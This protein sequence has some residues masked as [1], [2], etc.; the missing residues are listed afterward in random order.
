MKQK[1]GLTSQQSSHNLQGVLTAAGWAVTAL[2]VAVTLFLLL[3]NLPFV[4]DAMD[5]SYYARYAV[6]VLGGLGVGYL[7]ARLSLDKKREQSRTKIAPVYTGICFGLLTL[8]LCQFLDFTQEPMRALF[9]DLTYPWGR[10]FFLGRPL[11]ALIIVALLASI[12][13]AKGVAVSAHSRWLK[14]LF[15]CIFGVQQFVT[16]VFSGYIWRTADI[17]VTS[18]LIFLLQITLAPF[19]IAVVAYVV[20]GGIKEKIDRLFAATIIGALYQATLM[21]LVQFRTDASLR[22][23]LVFSIASLIVAYVCVAVLIFAARSVIRREKN[24]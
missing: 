16:I 21:M 15:I 24:I 14:R 20:L 10:L 13:Y 18:L 19:F 3:T 2:A 4:R 1:I 17:S 6:M 9:G 5:I 12:V 7:F 8:T 22:T 11:G 23:S